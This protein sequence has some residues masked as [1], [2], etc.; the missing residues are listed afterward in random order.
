MRAMDD[1][2]LG[3]LPRPEL[4]DGIHATAETFELESSFLSDSAIGWN[5]NFSWLAASVD[6]YR[7]TCFSDC[8]QVESSS[9]RDRAPDEQ[10]LTSISYE[11]SFAETQHFAELGDVPLEFVEEELP[12]VT[13]PANVWNSIVGSAFGQFQEGAPNL[14]YPWEQ[15]VMGEIFG[16]LAPLHY[17]LQLVKL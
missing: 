7:E 1:F 14:R 6:D 5:R 4:A 16:T 17:Q 15:G 9:C 8:P 11:P 2:E 13:V 12:N 3:N 10:S